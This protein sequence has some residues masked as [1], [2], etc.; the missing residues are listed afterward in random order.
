MG[1]EFDGDGAGGC[2]E[3]GFA[4]GLGLEVIEG[5]HDDDADYCRDPR[6]RGITS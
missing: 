6:L 3:D 1:E 2:V 4:G 5:R